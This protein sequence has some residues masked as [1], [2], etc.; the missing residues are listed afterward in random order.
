MERSHRFKINQ[1]FIKIEEL[2]YQAIRYYRLEYTI[3]SPY[4]IT[5]NSNTNI[6]IGYYIKSIVGNS[7]SS[8]KTVKN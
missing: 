1:T 3:I 6:S 5:S 8:K 4:E 2:D 7:H